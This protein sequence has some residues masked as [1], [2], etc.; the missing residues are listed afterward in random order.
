[1]NKLDAIQKLIDGHKV[2]RKSWDADMHIFMEESGNTYLA[3]RINDPNAVD[4]CLNLF[5]ED[6]WE[7]WVE[8]L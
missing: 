1:L 7:V 3:L 6:G 2:R 5:P 8:H 4:I